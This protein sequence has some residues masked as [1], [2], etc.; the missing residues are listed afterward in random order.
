MA[1]KTAGEWWRG[2]LIYQVYPRS[3]YDSNQDGTGDL[4]GITQKLDYIKSLGVD[5]IWISPFFTSP[6]KDF[7]YDVSNYE[8][9]DPIFGNLSDFD[10]LVEGCN[11]R[12]LKVMIDLVISHTSDEHPWFK[13]SRTS[14]TNPKADWYV[15]AEAKPDGTPPNNWLSIFGG[16]AWEWDA[17]RRQ[18][19]LHNFLRSQPDLNFHNTDVQ[20]AMLDVAKFWLEKGVH[21]F[22]LDTVNYYFHDPKLRSNPVNKDTGPRDDVPASNP[23][24]RQKH[25]WD[26]NRPE[27]LAF[28]EKLR[29]LMDNYPHTA[30]VGEVGESNAER[31]IGQYTQKGKRLHMAYSFSLLGPRFSAAH[32]RKVVEGHKAKMGSG[33]PCWAFSNHDVIRA[34]TRWTN[35]EKQRDA[36]AKMLAALLTTLRG[37]VCIYQGE[38][39]GLPEADV[40]YE[41]LQD[42]YGKQ[43]WPDFKGRDGCRTPMPWQAR[44]PHGGFT[45]VEPWLPVPGEHEARAVD[46]QEAKP[47]SVLNHYRTFMAW[48]NQFPALRD[49]GITFLEADEPLMVYVRQKG[50]EKIL[51]VIN[52]GGEEVHFDASELSGTI[53]P[54]EGHGFASTIKENRVILP[55]YAAAFGKL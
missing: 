9:V 17:T 24:G 47:D 34:A 52:L 18:Y 45:T 10:D 28:L 29:Q 53:T 20:K 37:S 36:F 22:R 31:L 39:L 49:G 16:S 27:N 48:R 11:Q 35:D 38:E 55:P 25:I 7:G 21:G 46:E 44:K 5:A 1:A 19:Y 23:Y 2:G 15:W 8:D 32:I 40:P 51:V 42:P 6:M 4:A 26:K 50:K 30:A 3:F 14:K 12:G 13:E 41:L 54:L 33:W 43:F